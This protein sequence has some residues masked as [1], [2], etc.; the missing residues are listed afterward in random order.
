MAVQTNS[1][2]THI[3]YSAEN[4]WFID[5][6]NG[7]VQAKALAIT[8]PASAAAQLLQHLHSDVSDDLHNI[9][10]S[11][12]AVV[13]QAFERSDFTSPPIGFGA[14][15]SRSEQQ[16][17]LLGILF[18]SH[19]YPNRCPANLVMTRSLLGGSIVPDIVFAD[20]SVLQSIS[21]E[22]HRT[23]FDSPN[24]RPTSVQTI[25]WKN[26]I[27]RYGPGHWA[28]QKR[29]HQFHQSNHYTIL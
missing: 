13:M 1:P 15:Q 2:A 21:L 4:G 9:E 12:V 5:T 8:C 16:S 14:L 17:G 10:Y 11:P 23:L 18:T 25:R 7:Q 28:F 20:D 22:A 27:P 6:P 24:L 19:L 3:D 29:M 26:A